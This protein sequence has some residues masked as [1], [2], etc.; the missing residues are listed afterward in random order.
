MMIDPATV[1]FYV[2]AGLREFKQ[3]LFDRV[4][5]RLQKRGGKIVRADV[6][7]LAKLVKEDGRLPVVGCSPELTDLILEWKATKTPWCY[8][9]RGYVRRTHA[10][11]LPRGQ[12]GGH[13]RWHLNSF[14]LQK[15]HNVPDDRWRALQQELRPWQKGGKHIVVAMPTKTYREF[16]RIQGWTDT[17]IEKLALLTKRKI[18]IRE[19]QTQLPLQESLQGAHCLVTHGSNSAVEAVILGYPVIVDP[20]SAAAVVGRTKLD[21]IENLIYPDRQPWLNN[22]A[23]SCFTEPEMEA[24]K[25]WSMIA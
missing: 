25:M 21:D 3:N 18:E 8:W 23:Y 17:T 7:L 9:D 13:Y 10:T 20:C 6:P 12:N 24:G 14:Q 1:A 16:H 22:L 2:P 4:G 11:W 15:L 5:H 19:K